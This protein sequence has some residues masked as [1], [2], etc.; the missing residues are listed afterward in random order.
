MCVIV[1]CQAD[2]PSFIK[3]GCSR[4]SLTPLYSGNC[5]ESTSTGFCMTLPTLSVTNKLYTSIIWLPFW[6]GCSFCWQSPTNAAHLISVGL[7]L[8]Q[9]KTV[10]CPSLDTS[11]CPPGCFSVRYGIDSIGEENDCTLMH[12]WEADQKNAKIVVPWN[13]WQEDFDGV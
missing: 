4:I 12:V 2:I 6:I 1:C 5:A 8:P 9:S 13:R 10:E 3:P 7:A 11:S